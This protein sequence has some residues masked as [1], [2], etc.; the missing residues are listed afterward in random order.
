MIKERLKE[1]REQQH[2]TQKEFAKKI[3][4]SAKTVINW[5]NG[6][7]P[8]IQNLKELCFRL[9]VSADYLL[10][11]K[12]KASIDISDMCEEDQVI[13]SAIIQCYRETKLRYREKQRNE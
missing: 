5:E 9:H 13:V 8:S 11:M 4:V 10:G 7:P 2:L 3:G 1:I 12:T 6:A